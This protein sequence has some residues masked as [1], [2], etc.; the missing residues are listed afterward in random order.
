MVLLT[1]KTVQR[2]SLFVAFGGLVTTFITTFLPLWKTMNSE[3]N[4]MENWYEGLW[5]TCI[6]TEEVGLQCKAFESLLT[7]PPV[8]LVSRILMCVSIASGFLGVLA[9]FFGLEGVEVGAGRERLKR[10]LL[11]LGGVL[12]LVSGMT[13]L[14]PV[15]LIAY[16]MVLEFWDEGLP[17]VM[18]RWEYGEAMFSAWFSG[19]LLVIGGSFLFVAV[20]MGDHQAK[21]QR[22]ISCYNHTLQHQTLGR[23]NYSKTEIL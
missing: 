23:Q 20:C 2:V 18:P 4:E 14:A 13:T 9:A 15:S 16:V 10:N 7:L 3:L 12:I 1:I 8:T 22:K 6:F 19:L 11:I 17:D 21:Q 5:H